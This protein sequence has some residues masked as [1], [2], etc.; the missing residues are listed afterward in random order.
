ML[1]TSPFVKRVQ[2]QSK[3]LVNGQTTHTQSGKNSKE[4]ARCLGTTKTKLHM[5]PLVQRSHHQN[6]PLGNGYTTHAFF[7]SKG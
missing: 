3:P 6:E 1:H 5:P 2:H 4:L 7:G